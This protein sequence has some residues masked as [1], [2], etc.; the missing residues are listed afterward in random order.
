MVMEIPAM[1]DF[2]RPNPYAD[3]GAN[4]TRLYANA[5]LSTFVAAASQGLMLWSEF[6]NASLPRWP[7]AAAAMPVLRPLESALLPAW[8]ALALPWL[9]VARASDRVLPAALAQR[10]TI[11]AAQ[12]AFSAYRSDG[13]HAVAQIIHG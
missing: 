12:Q 3:L 13:G 11:E 7:G 2:T 5:A 9:P 1:L 10:Q 4:L 6:L 8:P